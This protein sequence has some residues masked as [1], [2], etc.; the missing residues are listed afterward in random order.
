MYYQLALKVKDSGLKVVNMWYDNLKE[1]T[2]AFSELSYG[3][4]KNVA[5]L[6]VLDENNNIVCTSKEA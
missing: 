5:E 4:N 3:V 6:C 1:A 2:E